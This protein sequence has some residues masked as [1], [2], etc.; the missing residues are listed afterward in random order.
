MRHV[1]RLFL[2]HALAAGQTLRLDRDHAHRLFTV[3]RLGVGAELRVFNGRDGEWAATVVEV[4]KRGGVL[5]CDRQTAADRAPADVWLCFAPIKKDRTEFIVE[6]ATELGAARIVPMLTAFTNSDRV[7]VDRLQAH[8]LAAVEQCGGTIVPEVAEPVKFE[9][10][11]KNWS[12]DRRIMFC[13][14]DA[15]AGDLPDQR[16]PW[17]ILI[18]PEGGFSDAERDRLRAVGHT[19]TLGPRILRADTAAVAALTLWQSKLGDWS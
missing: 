5:L 12:D 11:L 3:M 6:K 18:G 8:A 9:A 1:V 4:G 15:A 19:V 13:D 2:D 10:L 14:E 17:A 16:G 7:R